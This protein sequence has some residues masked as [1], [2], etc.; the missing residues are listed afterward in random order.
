MYHATI[1]LPAGADAQTR[2]SFAIRS[3]E[4]ADRT[5][6]LRAYIKADGSSSSTR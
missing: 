2:A 1:A 5:A 3:R 6:F 4:R